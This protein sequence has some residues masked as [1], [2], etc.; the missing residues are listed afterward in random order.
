LKKKTSKIP[1]RPEMVIAIP[2]MMFLGVCN[3]PNLTLFVT[4][5]VPGALI[6]ALSMRGDQEIVRKLL[7][8]IA[9]Q[10]VMFSVLADTH[11]QISESLIKAVMIGDP[12]IVKELLNAGAD[13]KWGENAALRWA[14][15]E[16][17]TE[18]ANTLG[19]A[20]KEPK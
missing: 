17:K 11:G 9:N 13:P 4:D 19:E 6:D 16:G 18:I 14:K 5:L 1:V 7:L 15:S 8:N 2:T 10:E 3:H 20:M 12:E